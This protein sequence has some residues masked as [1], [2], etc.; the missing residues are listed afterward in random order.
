MAE[1]GREGFLREQGYLNLSF[2]GDTYWLAMD[3]MDYGLAACPNLQGYTAQFY[4]PHSG[5][6]ARELLNL[7][8][9]A[10][11]APETRPVQDLSPA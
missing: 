11:T 3:M 4:L 9:R 10:A 6:V 8:H 1:K 5:Y 2:S 7:T